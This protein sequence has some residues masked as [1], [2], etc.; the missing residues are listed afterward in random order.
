MNSI[1][2]K[3]SI[4]IKLISNLNI[5]IELIS[6]RYRVKKIKID[7]VYGLRNISRLI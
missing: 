5:N 2:S 7:L 6:G 4:N 1:S 3:Y